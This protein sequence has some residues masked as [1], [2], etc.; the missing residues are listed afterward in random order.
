MKNYFSTNL[1][2]LREKNN[3]TKSKLGELVGVNQTTIGRW[4]SNIITPSIDNVVDVLNAFK[5]P[6]SELGTFLG[7]D[8]KNNTSH[9]PTD[10]DYK[11]LLKEK[12]L[13][14]EN[15]N[16]N[17]ESLNKLLKIADILEGTK[18]EDQK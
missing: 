9:E 6:I 7:T 16:I 5:I 12:G 11:Q 13:M 3:M 14:D 17:E 8:M 1:K 4:E 18:K 10:N 2:Y 15:E